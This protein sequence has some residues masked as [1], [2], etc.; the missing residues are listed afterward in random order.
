MNEQ[1]LAS[2]KAFLQHIASYLK[3]AW[4]QLEDDET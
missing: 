3:E 2:A 4:G 1:Q